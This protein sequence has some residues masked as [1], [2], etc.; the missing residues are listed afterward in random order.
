MNPHRDSV[1]S[2]F[3]AAAASY[4]SGASVQAI[5]AD[6][7]M[8][9]LPA[10]G[11]VHRILDVGCGTGLL[12]RRLAARFPE[13]SVEALDQAP[14]MIEAARRHAPGVSWHA[15]DLLHFDSGARYDLIASN[16]SLH[17]IEPLE[18]GLRR[19]R[20]L[21]APEGRLVFSIM[22][23]GTLGELREARLVAAP[24][25]PPLGRLPTATDVRAALA[26]AGWDILRLREEELEEHHPSARD[27]LRHIHDTGL[28]GGTVS[29]AAVALTRNE[30]ARLIFE[31]DRRHQ[32]GSPGVKA[33]YEVAY[34]S[35]AGAG[36]PPS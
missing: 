14:R 31:Y 9:L 10:A 1:R 8:D 6:R 5:V 33:T 13:A 18:A 21:L 23:D 3:N 20:G 12:T 4:E 11:S 16:C 2:R 22:L 17:W 19:L 7:L 25:K 27:F 35:A 34:V 15:A 24:A 28:T 26:G 30:L 32:D 36:R 29:R